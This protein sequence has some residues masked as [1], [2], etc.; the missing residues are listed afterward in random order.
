MQRGLSAVSGSPAGASTGTVHCSPCVCLGGRRGWWWGGGWGKGPG[1][2][3]TAGPGLAYV[4]EVGPTRGLG[5]HVPL[6]LSLPP[7]ALIATRDDPV[8]GYR[9]GFPFSHFPFLPLCSPR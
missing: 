6:F 9:S 3:R 1:V 2:A 8:R 4:S 5:K 7:S